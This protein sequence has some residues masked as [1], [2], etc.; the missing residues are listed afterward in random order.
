MK[1]PGPKWVFPKA[2][3]CQLLWS[4]IADSPSP[5]PLAIQHPVIPLE[6]VPLWP[7]V[8]HLMLPP[9]YVVAFGH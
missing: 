6:L 9:C 1:H 8:E 7:S 4:S 3:P 2:W 5:T